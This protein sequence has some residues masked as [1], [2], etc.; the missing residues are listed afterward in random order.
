MGE[1]QLKDKTQIIYLKYGG[2][3]DRHLLVLDKGSICEEHNVG[4]T[5]LQCIRSHFLDYMLPDFLEDSLK[6]HTNDR[7]IIDDY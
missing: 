3:F 5:I 2:G 4:R 7:M 6:Y 1:V